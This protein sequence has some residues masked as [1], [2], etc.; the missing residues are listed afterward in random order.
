MRDFLL[1]WTPFRS[2]VVGTRYRCINLAPTREIL[3]AIPEF[4]VSAGKVIIDSTWNFSVIAASESAM[5]KRLTGQQTLDAS[6]KLESGRAVGKV[7][8]E[9]D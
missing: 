9:I 1:V 3:D 4:L 8:V 5:P 6:A 2:W 7:V